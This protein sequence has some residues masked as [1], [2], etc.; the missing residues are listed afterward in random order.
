[1][2][3]GWQSNALQIASRVDSF[4]AFA[5]PVFKIERLAWVIP[6]FSASSCD[7][8][9]RLASITSTLITIGIIKLLSLLDVEDPFLF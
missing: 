4:T 1:M 5:F 8:I 3:P 2:S 9:L 6:I 7:C